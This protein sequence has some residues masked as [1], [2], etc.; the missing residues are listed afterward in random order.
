[1]NGSMPFDR[2]IEKNNRNNALRPKALT[3]AATL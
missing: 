1:M 3:A 2:T